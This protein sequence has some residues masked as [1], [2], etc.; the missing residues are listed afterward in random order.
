MGMLTGKKA[1]IIGLA[2]S[3]SIAAGVAQAFHDQGAELALSYQNDRLKERV[4]KMSAGWNCSHMYECDVTSD[5]SIDAMMQQIKANWGN[6]DIIVHSVAFAPRECL[7][8]DYLDSITREGFAM[9]HDISSY[10]LAAICKAAKPL[11]NDGGSVLT[12]TYLGS[13]RVAVNYNVM[14]VAKASLEANVRYLAQ[15]LGAQGVRV[16]SISAGPIKTL[17]AAGIAG[18]R[19]M[20]AYNEKVAPLHRNVTIE[21]VGQT[22][23]FLCSDMASGITGEILHVDGGFHCMAVPTLDVEETAG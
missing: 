22:S 16:N 3:R 23:A 9:A 15:S 14:G 7:E 5:D 10:S 6:F 20:L 17:A 19:T 4:E 21:E 8:G 2:S 11:L 1:L 12:M 18:F 13:T